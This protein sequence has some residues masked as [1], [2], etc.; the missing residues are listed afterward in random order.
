MASTSVLALFFCILEG[1]SCLGSSCAQAS[2]H[3]SLAE[4]MHAMEPLRP[5]RALTREEIISV[6]D[7][8]FELGITGLMLVEN[9]GLGVTK[10]VL[11]QLAARGAPKGVQVVICG[12][13]GG[14]AGDGYVLARHLVTHGYTPKVAFCGN[15]TRVNREDTTGINL[16]ILERMGVD[17]QDVADGPGLSAL[18]ASWS[19]AVFVVDALLGYGLKSELRDDYKAWI[20]VINNAPQLKIAVD[21]PSGLDA[22]TGKPWG[23]AVKA[24]HTV[25]NTARKTGFDEP[26]ALEFTGT[27]HVTTICPPLCWAHLSNL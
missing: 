8:A 10:V 24:V 1:C 14:N 15:R 5:P 19:D 26:G 11:E 23:A 12:G 4:K 9:A 21:M 6:D 27:V 18:F 20:E 13:R 25:T 17:I 2:T 16:S 7:K 3:M 22:N